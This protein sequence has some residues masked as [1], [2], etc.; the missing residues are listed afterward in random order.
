MRLCGSN[1]KFICNN[2]IYS[3]SSA[4]GGWKIA[5]DGDGV[6]TFAA[7]GLNYQVEYIDDLIANPDV[8]QRN[9]AFGIPGQ[10]EGDTS[11]NGTY[12]IH[13]TI[14][15]GVGGGLALYFA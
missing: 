3:R 12:R 5:V 4:V 11:A 8:R 10:T 14:E 2:R 9:V 7:N 6:L 13:G 1:I 15:V